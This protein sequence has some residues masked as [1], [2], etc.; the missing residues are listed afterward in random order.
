[1]EFILSPKTSTIPD[2][3]ISIE[4]LALIW[5]GTTRTSFLRQMNT[6]ETDP[7]YTKI[8]QDTFMGHVYGN[9]LYF[10]TSVVPQMVKGWSDEKLVGFYNEDDLDEIADN[11]TKEF[12]A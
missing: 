12:N 11:F 8:N 5:D 4:A 10:H 2:D 9:I 7:F 3:K 6:H 1:M